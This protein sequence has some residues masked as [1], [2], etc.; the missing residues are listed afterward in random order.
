MS[1][2]EKVL[3]NKLKEYK[4]GSI[5]GQGSFGIVHILEM[6]K[7]PKYVIKIVNLTDPDYRNKFNKEKELFK[8]LTN[9]Q[10]KCIHRNI[11][12]HLA[13]ENVGDCGYI[14]AKYYDTDLDNFLKEGSFSKKVHMDNNNLNIF[15]KWIKL[16]IDAVRYIHSKNIAHGDLKPQNILIRYSDYNLVITDFDTMCIG[17]LLNSTCYVDG[18]THLY[19]SPK[20]YY[21]YRKYIS[22]KVVKESDIWAVAMI[23]LVMWFGIDKLV[24]ILYAESIDNMFPSMYYEKLNNDDFQTLYN[25][26]NNEVENYKISKELAM[27]KDN[28]DKC[29]NIIQD[30][31]TYSAQILHKIYNN[32]HTIND[33]NVYLD[34]LTNFSEFHIR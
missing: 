3:S 33:I 32:K 26:I 18:L 12:C 7:A 20:L 21:S 27:S 24:N 1:Q 4:I 29:A 15:I 10:V 13:V 30:I 14:I 25:V 11:N 31:L 2:C 22:I 23:I 34:K 9:K 19:A 5:I 28:I 16:L 17:K 8:L 6:D